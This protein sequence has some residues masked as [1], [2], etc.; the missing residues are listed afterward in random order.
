MYRGIVC[1]KKLLPLIVI[2]PSYSFRLVPL[3][4]EVL[5]QQGKMHQN[6]LLLH[7]REVDLQILPFS[8]CCI[9]VKTGIE[10]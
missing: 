5:W 10:H 8:A 1:K 3:H 7:P 6:L 2:V 9:R 4:D